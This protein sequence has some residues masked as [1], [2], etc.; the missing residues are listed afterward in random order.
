MDAVTVEPMNRIDLY[1]A[2]W[3]RPVFHVAKQL[4]ISDRGLAKVCQRMDVP[5][6]PRGYWRRVDTGQRLEAAPLPRP[7]YNPE[8]VMD[9]VLPSSALTAAQDESKLLPVK[10]RPSTVTTKT[11]STAEEATSL[12][13]RNEARSAERRRAVDCATA[14]DQYLSVSRL[15]AHLE[16]ML[17]VLS[18]EMVVVVKQWVALQR[19]FL[20]M[21]HPVEQLLRDLQGVSRNTAVPTWWAETDRE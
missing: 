5:T 1:R 17:P 13:A 19:E 18:P 2:V 11:E 4:G 10:E 9:G 6:P 15:L 7:D 8:V 14:L 20:R 12:F 16:T 21:N 3:A